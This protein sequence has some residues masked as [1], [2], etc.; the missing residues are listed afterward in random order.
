VY[1][2]FT[3]ADD[4][5][6]LYIGGALVV[7]NNQK[8]VV[9]EKSGRI[10]LKAGKHAIDVVYLDT[11]GA[12]IFH[13][14]KY[15]G[16]GVAKQTIPASRVFRGGTVSTAPV[17]VAPI[18]PAPTTPTQPAP[19][20]FSGYYALVA[21]H[22][23]KSIDV[24]MAS[25]SDGAPAFQ[26]TY[27]SATNQQWSLVDVGSGYYKIVARHSG[28]VLAVTSS[29]GQTQQYT[30]TGAAM[31]QWKVESTGDGYYKITNRG[32][33][34]VLDVEG[35][36]TLDKTRILQWTYNGGNNQKW[37]LQSV[38]SAR[39]A[40]AETELEIAVEDVSVFPN[41]AKDM[42]QLTYNAKSDG[43]ATVVVSDATS[44][45]R[46]TKTVELHT[47][48]NVVEL[49]VGNLQTGIYFLH[50]TADGKEVTKKLIVAK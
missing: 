15:E 2:F 37:K 24:S 21:K 40:S 36:S 42:V 5:C 31:Q 18:E 43:K 27:K 45:D 25:T 39:V 3:Y 49:N 9:A 11:Q 34:K 6:D 14:V 7:S 16:P 19:G 8:N 10:E 35:A 41:P 22:S 32:S 33:G 28:K 46:L 1:T 4:A 30:Y 50:F 17:V 44:Q 29:T 13:H 12:Q 20:T 26:Y 38:G 48:N 23:G 47:G